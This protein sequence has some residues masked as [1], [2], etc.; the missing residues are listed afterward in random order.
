ML[1]P[2]VRVGPDGFSILQVGHVREPG[3]RLRLTYGILCG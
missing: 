1:Q 3:W 2:K